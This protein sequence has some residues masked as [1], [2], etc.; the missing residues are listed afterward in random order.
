M[1]KSLKKL[2]GAHFEPSVQRPDNTALWW[3]FHPFPPSSFL[4]ALYSRY[5]LTG[6]SLKLN[7]GIMKYYIN[8]LFQYSMIERQTTDMYKFY[9]IL[10]INKYW[11]DTIVTR[12]IPLG[13]FFWKAHYFLDK[14][15]M[16]A[17]Q[18][19]LLSVLL[20]AWQRLCLCGLFCDE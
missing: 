6:A 12:L 20:F 2:Q 15:E 5:T 10:K 19:T 16:T 9:K 3:G 13:W 18:T 14:S 17:F 8:P 1:Q 7:V 4:S 11:I